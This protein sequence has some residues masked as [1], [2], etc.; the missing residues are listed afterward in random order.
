MGFVVMAKQLLFV[1]AVFLVLSSVYCQED[2][3]FAGGVFTAADSTVMF[4]GTPACGQVN[5]QEERIDLLYDAA[6]LSVNRPAIR[7][8][9]SLTFRLDGLLD[10]NPSFRIMFANCDP[11]TSICG[12]FVDMSGTANGP[13]IAQNAGPAPGDINYGANNLVFNLAADFDLTPN[14]DFA[15]RIYFD[16]YPVGAGVFGNT[17]T[18]ATGYRVARTC[19]NAPDMTGY[20]YLTGLQNEIAAPVPAFAISNCGVNLISGISC[21]NPLQFGTD[22]NECFA[23]ISDTQITATTSD[24]ILAPANPQ[25]CPILLTSSGFNPSMQYPLGTFDIP[26][27]VTEVG[28]GNTVRPCSRTHTVFDNQAPTVICPSNTVLDPRFCNIVPPPFTVVENCPNPTIT[29]TPPT[30]ALTFSSTV[31]VTVNVRDVGGATDSCSYQ[32]TILDPFSF[33]NCPG[34]N[35]NPDLVPF[36][37]DPQKCSSNQN[38]E[39]YVGS[40][41]TGIPGCDENDLYTNYDAISHDYPVGTVEFVAV[42]HSGGDIASTCTFEITVDDVEPPTINCPANI[43]V[44]QTEPT[45]ANVLFPDP[46]VVDNYPSNV[47]V[48]SNFQSGDFFPLGQSTVTFMANDGVASASCFF[49]VLVENRVTVASSSQ[50]PVNLPT[51]TNT[52]SQTRTAFISPEVSRD[53]VSPSLSSTIS[54]S[55]NPSVSPTPPPVVPS[56]SQTPSSTPSRSSSPTPSSTVTATPSQTPSTSHIPP[57][58]TKSPYVPSASPSATPEFFGVI[59]EQVGTSALV[60]L[61]IPC[62]TKICSNA[63]GEFYMNAFAVALEISFSDIEFVGIHGNE[64]TL[65]VCNSSGTAD[66]ANSI[67]NDSASE[68]FEGVFV[69]NVVF[70]VSCDDELRGA[71]A[72]Q[73]E[74][75][76]SATILSV[77]LLFLVSLFACK[78]VGN[79]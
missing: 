11:T 44:T 20:N 1:F 79:H 52:N 63:E 35:G 33:P 17:D 61:V 47:V 13:I 7:A 32:L 12:T 41:P 4:T 68:A 46:V 78:H 16:N 58:D 65:I 71:Q 75:E 49:E 48:T 18:S 74:T 43:V 40:L 3:A 23:T 27:T 69:E 21:V 45:G 42:A 62:Q 66:L 2:F 34:T 15:I 14:F 54:R 36:P 10:T 19:D 38:M 55:G 26:S 76:S 53:Q 6:S 5:F 37:N 8:G 59:Y 70:G 67:N 22:Q 72:I 25:F 30:S 60:E 51:V 39:F 24:V 77:T 56:E 29:Q 31:I 73:A 64:V 57:S 50:T 9:D 28:S